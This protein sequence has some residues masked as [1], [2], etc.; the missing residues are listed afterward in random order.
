MR[1]PLIGT[2]TRATPRPS[3]RRSAK[4]SGRSFG[5]V[6][7][8]GEQREDR[9]DG[10]GGPEEKDAPAEAHAHGASD[11][12]RPI[13]LEKKRIERLDEESLEQ[14]KCLHRGQEGGDA[15]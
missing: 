4:L 10:D 2:P 3:A 12:R 9:H 11:L 15:E 8:D 7:T 1:K 5:E 13:L 14:E 6:E